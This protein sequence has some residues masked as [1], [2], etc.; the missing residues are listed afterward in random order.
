VAVCPLVIAATPPVTNS[1]SRMSSSA[2]IT[3][4][5]PLAAYLRK[6]PA[7]QSP[8]DFFS[9]GAKQ[10]FLSSLRFGSKGLG[11]FSTDDLQAELTD[12]EIRQVLSLFDAQ[13]YAAHPHG[14]DADGVA[15][16]PP[17]RAKAPGCPE[18]WIEQ[19]FNQFHGLWESSMTGESGESGESGKSRQARSR[20]F[21]R[22]YHEWFA[23]EQQPD[24]LKILS[25][26]D[27]KLL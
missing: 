19:R 3:S 6:T 13:D 10:R 22:R 12:D 1:R 18:S 25:D 11:G 20:L 2:P 7:G 23:T 16:R 27:L 26:N 8:L 9:A 21:S 24:K 15:R 14:V 17:C 5:D 4:A